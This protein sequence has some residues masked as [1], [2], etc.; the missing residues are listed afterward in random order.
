VLPAQTF[1]ADEAFTRRHDPRSIGQGYA[2]F[3]DCL[4]WE[5]GFSCAACLLHEHD[6][7]SY[8]GTEGW[9]VM[10]IEHVVARSH[11]G[12]LAGAYG[13]V[14]FVCRFCN[15]ARS[16]APHIDSSGRRLL[17][18]TKDVWSK[19]F[20][21][22]GDHILPVKD[23]VDAAYTEDIYEINDPRKVKLRRN[24][25]LR[26]GDFLKALE[27]PR[28]RMRQLR[29]RQETQVTKEIAEL[30]D[31]VDRLC[32][33]ANLNEWIPDDAPAKCRCERA[34]AR[35]LPAS[36]ERQIFKIDLP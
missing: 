16:D 13:N 5:F 9:G 11:D 12:H 7:I 21:V 4:R 34:S 22:E 15:G 10:H 14:I 17:D 6:I 28:V 18:P 27:K 30:R 1:P 26:L 19:H 31:E 24:R 33:L 3:R 2:V 32:R 8:G 29:L 25:R 36:Y 23:D 20:R 35:N